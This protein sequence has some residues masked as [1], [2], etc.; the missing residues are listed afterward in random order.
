MITIIAKFTVKPE[1]LNRYHELIT[2]L[3]V[4]SRKEKSCL[5]YDLYKDIQN[6]NGFTLIEEW[7]DEEAIQEHNATPHFIEIAPVLGELC[8]QPPEVNLYHKL[9]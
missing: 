1:N 2:R 3:Q 7:K 9:A 4:A 5:R 8:S 6:E